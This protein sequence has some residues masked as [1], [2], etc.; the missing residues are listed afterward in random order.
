MKKKMT[1][2]LLAACVVAGAWG[3]AGCEVGPDYRVPADAC[4]ARV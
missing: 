3:M 4:S 1:I 2:P